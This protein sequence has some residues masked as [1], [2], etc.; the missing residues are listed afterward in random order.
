ME[1]S[2]LDETRE[3]LLQ[4][5]EELQAELEGLDAEMRTLGMDQDEEHGGLGNHFAEDGTNVIEQERI[6]ALSDDIRAILQ[7]V[8]QALG[9]IKN[10]TYGKCQRCGK[11]IMEERLEAFPYV[12]YC[13]E[14]QSIMERQNAQRPR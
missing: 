4:R 11:P 3:I 7:Q 1:A 9:R 10:G 14:C 2:K 13:I 5:R 6:V 12:A 8:D